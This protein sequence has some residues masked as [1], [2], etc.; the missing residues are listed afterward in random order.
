MSRDGGQLAVFDVNGLPDLGPDSPVFRQAAAGGMLPGD[1]LRD[2]LGLALEAACEPEAAAGTLD[3]QVAALEGT[4]LAELEG[5]EAEEEGEEGLE[6]DAELE[7]EGGTAE[8]R[9]GEGADDMLSE[10]EVRGA[11]CEGAAAR[12]REPGPW[13][14]CLRLCRAL[15]CACLLR[16]LSASCSCG[17]P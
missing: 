13:R 4:D 10:L 5:E 1:L 7:E 17:C 3:S 16:L 6:G 8:R 2:V 12:G 14:S 11:C 15:W 9:G